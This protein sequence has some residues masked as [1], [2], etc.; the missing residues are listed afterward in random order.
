MKGVLFD[1]D[2][3]LIHSEQAWFDAMN[4]VAVEL[5]CPPITREVF[6]ACWGQGV[7][8]D[9]VDHYGGADPAQIEALYARTVPR[10]LHRLTVP[11]PTV[12]DD[13]RALGLRVAV[14]T[15][16]PQP[17][18]D[19]SLRIAGLRAQVV[20]AAGDAPAKPHPGLLQLAMRRL[21]L[22]PNEVV[23]VGDSASD[24]GAARAAGVRLIGVGVPGWRSVRH[25]G[26]LL[27]LDL[28]ADL[29]RHR[30]H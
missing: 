20:C 4:E 7:E 16:T 9:A 25:V 11:C 6:D 18:A 10:H 19:Q 2:G 3:V 23:M 5:G 26:E 14:V 1:M 30:G 24:A 13:V 29:S 22:G 21:D 12:L 15:N 8:Q 28:F 27:A 17:L